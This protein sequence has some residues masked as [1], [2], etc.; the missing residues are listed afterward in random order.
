MCSPLACGLAR[1]ADMPCT[2]CPFCTSTFRGSPTSAGVSVFGACANTTTFVATTHSGGSLPSSG[3][4]SP[5]RLPAAACS[6]PWPTLSASTSST[7]C[8]SSLTTTSRRAP[9]PTTSTSS[10]CTRSTA[11][12]ATA[13]SRPLA[14]RSSAS[15]T[16]ARCRCGTPPTL[17]T[18]S[19]TSSAAPWATST[20]RSSTTCFRAC[21]TCTSPRS[22]RS[23]ARPARSLES[24]TP[25][26]RRSPTPGTRSSSLCAPS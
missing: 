10:R 17:P 24:R 15:R 20:S 26:T 25:P 2:D 22:R 16:G 21:P 23:F 9:S 6:S 14:R 19:S 5:F 7:R 3:A 1:C 12:T 11:S 13:A 8:A 4:R 18:P